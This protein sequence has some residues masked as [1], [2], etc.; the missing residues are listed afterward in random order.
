ML[1]MFFNAALSVIKVRAD[2]M[3]GRNDQE[4]TTSFFGSGLF[5]DLDQPAPCSGLITQ[6]DLCYYRPIVSFHGGSIPI[7]LQVWRFDDTLSGGQ[8]V[9]GYEAD[10]DIPENPLRFQ[11]I[12]I[13][14]PPEDRLNITEG[15]FLGVWM[16]HNATLPVVKYTFDFRHLLHAP[17]YTF[18]GVRVPTVVVYP[19][20]SDDIYYSAED[21]AIHLSAS[22]AGIAHCHSNN[23][24][25]IKL[26][27]CVLE[28]YLQYKVQIL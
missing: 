17:P 18:A 8:K 26:T 21:L 25:R 2:C 19:T 23:S 10:V 11:C 7:E 3:F 28:H 14:V 16:F 13:E 15:D 9:V 6:W 24:W 1:R 22:I 12:S 27:T 20:T 4:E 5:I